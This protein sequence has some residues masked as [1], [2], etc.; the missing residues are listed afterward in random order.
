MIS[1]TCWHHKKRSKSNKTRDG[2]NLAGSWFST[3][4]RN[5]E[6]IFLPIIFPRQLNLLQLALPLKCPCRSSN[7]QCLPGKVSLC[8]RPGDIFLFTLNNTSK[9][10]LLHFMSCL[11]HFTWH[12]CFRLFLT[13]GNK[14]VSFSCPR[15]CQTGSRDHHPNTLVI[16]LWEALIQWCL[17]YLLLVRSLARS[18]RWPRPKVDMGLSSLDSSCFGCSFQI[19]WCW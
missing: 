7:T 18:S 17:P 10:L 9:F 12:K 2:L 11:R 5:H 6:P 14:P 15:P 13:R 4:D 1:N 3:T 8:P 16:C 19:L